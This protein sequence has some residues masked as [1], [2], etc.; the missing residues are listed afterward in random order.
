MILQNWWYTTLLDASVRHQPPLRGALKCDVA[1]IGGGM[2]GL[3]AALQLSRMGKK[4][5]LLERNICGG[6]STGKSAGFL[7]P[8]SELE[9]S[10]LVRRYGVDG[11]KTVW[12]MPVQGVKLI[13]QTINDF[14]IACDFRK[15]DSLFV[16]IGKSGAEDVAS[17]AKSRKRLGFASTKYNKDELKK[18]NAGL[19]Y[20]AGIRYDDTYSINPLLYAQG[21]KQALMDSGVQIF[22]STEVVRIE[23][24]A[25]I[26]HLGSVMADNFIVCIDKM[27]SEFSSVAKQTYHAQ[28]FLSISEPLDD[29]D[30]AA[31]F[32]DGEVQCWDSRLVYSYY[33]LTPDKRLLLGGGSA[34][35]TFSPNDINSP[36]IINQVIADFKKRFPKLE[37]VAFVQYWPG[38]IDTTK[39]IMP[40]IDW[41]DAPNVQYVLGCVG[42]PWASFCGKYAA[43]RLYEPRICQK[44]CMYLGAHRSFFI[45]PW[46]QSIVGKMISFSLNNAYAKYFEKDRPQM[47]QIMHAHKGELPSHR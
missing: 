12:N 4:V 36:A 19:G 32:P 43:E 40:I 31:I 15:Q 33:R 20:E 11:A 39:D 34:L 2:A 3:H 1:V 8:D 44:Y 9:L 42:L 14:N 25:A 13:K 47:S 35:T 30:I 6:S 24:G 29:N 45:P 46:L 38:R 23:D 28:T 5:I 21:L 26:T 17:E 16:G 18:V 37:H 7:T 10:Q 41:F 27:K 22:E